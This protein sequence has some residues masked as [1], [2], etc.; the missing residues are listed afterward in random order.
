V[1]AAG[2]AALLCLAGCGHDPASVAHGV[3]DAIADAAGDHV[4]VK[5][6]DLPTPIDLG[7]LPLQKLQD[8]VRGIFGD[9]SRQNVEIVCRAKE[10]AAAHVTDT[11]EQAIRRTLKT[12]GLHR[13]E[14]EVHKLAEQTER[15]VE[16]GLSPNEL[17]RAAVVWACRWA[18]S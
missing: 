1:V 4:T 12:L 15:A 18:S 6:P 3:G 16:S 17:T 8:R 10:L 9:E 7:D 11:S 14:A 2:M 13:P 5:L